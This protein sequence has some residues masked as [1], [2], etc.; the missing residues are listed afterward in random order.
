MSSRICNR[1]VHEQEHHIRP[2]IH[3]SPHS[4]FRYKQLVL[5][6]DMDPSFQYYI[7]NH[8]DIIKWKHFPPYWPFVRRIHQSPVNSPHKG[9]W[10]GALMFSLIWA[11]ING[12]VNNHEAGDLRHHCTHYDITV[13][14]RNSHYKDNV[15]RL[16]YLCNGY[17]YVWQDARPSILYCL[18]CKDCIW[19]KCV[20][21]IP[22]IKTKCLFLIKEIHM[23]YHTDRGCFAHF[24]TKTIF[25]GIGILNSRQIYLY[26]GSSYT[27]ILHQPTSLDRHYNIDGLI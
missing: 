9:Q 17:P 25:P 4:M 20:A 19:W 21:W 8:D 2:V 1:H 11:W 13:V 7:Y 5:I 18:Y 27:G 16:S 24:N 6:W 23:P 10:H 12:W 22:I 3:Y 15:I 26:Y 14:Y